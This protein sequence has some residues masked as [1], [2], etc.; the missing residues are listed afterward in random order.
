ML[1]STF[2]SARTQAVIA[3]G[4]MAALISGLKLDDVKAKVAGRAE[5]R[6]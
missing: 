5:G 2:S 3:G 6:C 4:G 1:T